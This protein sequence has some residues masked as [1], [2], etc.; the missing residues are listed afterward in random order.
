LDRNVYRDQI[1][2]AWRKPLRVSPFQVSL[3]PAAQI[4]I[5]TY[6]RGA[7]QQE[8]PGKGGAGSCGVRFCGRNNP[9]AWAQ[10]R[11]AASTAQGELFTP[12]LVDRAGQV[13]VEQ[14]A[15]RRM[16]DDH[17]QGVAAAEDGKQDAARQPH[18]PFKR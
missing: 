13:F 8:V 2:D 16:Q 6:R 3:Q 1:R 11:A 14:R 9:V 18:P 10:N 4:P 12:Q 15:G 7:V 5:F 17:S